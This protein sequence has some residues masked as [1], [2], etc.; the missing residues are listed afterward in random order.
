MKKKT[1][2]ILLADDDPDDRELFSEAITQKDHIVVQTVN[3]G[4]ELFAFLDAQSPDELPA[5]ILLDYN[6]PLITGPEI[7]QRLGTQS[8]Y[9]HIPKLVWSSS[10]R[11]KDIQECIRMGADSY[12]KKPSTNQEMEELL[13]QVDKI[14]SGRLTQ[15]SP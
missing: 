14:L 9:A 7:L 6:M 4:Q 13:H 12:I 5:L 10:A 8:T 2:Y 11:T 15:P 3:N 1:P